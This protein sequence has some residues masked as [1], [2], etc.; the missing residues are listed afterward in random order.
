M[1]Q[2]FMVLAWCAAA[3]ATPAAALEARIAPNAP[4]AEPVAGGYA[5][6]FD[7]LVD[8]G[9]AEAV[10][11]SSFEVAYFD[12]D[13]ARILLRQ[14]NGQGAVPNIL[15]VP[16]REIAAGEQRLYFNPFP[17]VPDDARVARIEVR[18]AF[19]N[20]SGETMSVAAEASPSTRPPTPMASPLTG[21]ILAWGGHD[22]MSHHRRW[23][24]VMPYLQGLGFASNAMRYAFDF[25]AVDTAGAL[26]APNPTRNEDWFGF[27][28]PLRA[29]ADGVVVRAVA[30][31][32]DDRSFDPEASHGD[33][34]ALFGNYLVIDHGG[35]VFSLMGHLKQ[36]GIGVAEGERVRRGQVVARVGNSGSAEFPDLHFQLMDGPDMRA[37]GVPVVF[38]DFVR[39]P[40]GERVRRGPI[41]TGEAVDA[42]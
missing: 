38:E 37:E 7:V 41:E 22:L 9:G 25:V 40:G 13:G 5:F 42:R 17:I 6:N 36:G 14:A 8:N 35:G 33:P 4:L 19:A 21:R 23:D 20:A 29:P 15:S 10:E 18:M 12:R 32:P 28:A 31:H 11:L 2:L 26:S 16:G 24:Y 39:T 30:H 3:W 1:R 34:N 27:D